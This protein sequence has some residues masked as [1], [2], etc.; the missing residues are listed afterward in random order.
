MRVLA[1]E[2]HNDDV[3]L[4]C[5]FSARRERA[6]V[7]T[8]LASFV[9]W[10]RASGITAAQ[11]T[12][13]SAAAMEVLGCT[14]EQWTHR[15]NAPNWCQVEADLADLAARHPEL[16]AVYAPAVESNGHEHH[17][18]VGAA[19]VEVFGRRVIAYTTYRRDL[20]RTVG[21]VEV[22]PTPNEIIAKL[23]ALACYRSQ[24]TE[25]ST[26]SWFTGGLAEY[27]C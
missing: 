6:H 3:A 12:A 4:F 26:R 24:I 13:E 21:Y 8:V 23:Q 25:M 9:Q 1:L 2:P 20:G 17:N 15:D 10:E 11:R 7:I 16:Q 18:A 22:T 27:T 5:A 19:A 14:Y